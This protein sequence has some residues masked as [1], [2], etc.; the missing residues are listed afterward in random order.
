MEAYC[1]QCSSTKALSRPS[2]KQEPVREH[3][4]VPPTILEVL[5][6]SPSAAQKRNPYLNPRGSLI[7]C[8]AWENIG[9]K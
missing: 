3:C 6:A 9:V 1:T 4:T 2:P 8:F 7:N 5:C